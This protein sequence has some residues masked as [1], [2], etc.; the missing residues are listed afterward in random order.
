MITGRR[1][2]KKEGPSLF[3][4]NTKTKKQGGIILKRVFL[5]FFLFATFLSGCS[6][7]QPITENSQGVWDHYFVYPMSKLLLVLGHLFHD[8]YGLAIITL[9]F[10]VRFV[11]LPF[12]LKQYKTTMKMQTLR[13]EI[14]K[15]QKKYQ[16]GSVQDQQKLQQEMM[17]L[18]QKHG[19]NP[20]SG[21]FPVFL[22]MPIFMA[23][24]YAISRTEEIKRHSFLWVQLGHQDPYFILPIL[25]AL[26]TFISLRLSP[27]ATGEKSPQTMI[28]SYIMPVMIFMGASS[29]PSALSLYWVIGGCFSI[30]QSLMI[31][32]QLKSLSNVQQSKG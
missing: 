13:P 4:H 19:I 18:Y 16:N 21:C 9:T 5:V 27:S 32:T 17:A 8:N 28:M 3:F 30:I 7:R 24:Y 6:S 10:I 22:Q 29:V 20:L 26:T 12:M 25:A 15:L 31:R 11:L 2:R 1:V 14:E 23:L